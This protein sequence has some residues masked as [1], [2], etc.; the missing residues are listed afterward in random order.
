M[1]LSFWVILSYAGAQT[2]ESWFSG[3]FIFSFVH[4]SS[5]FV[6]VCAC[7]GKRKTKRC[8]FFLLKNCKSAQTYGLLLCN[9]RKT[10]QGQQFEPLWNPKI[11]SWCIHFPNRICAIPI[12]ADSF[13]L[14]S[15]LC[16]TFLFDTRDGISVDWR[17]HLCSGR[18]L[19]I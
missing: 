13:G 10:S 11:E 15:R 17:E 16:C 9:P 7:R 18:S 14:I 6:S 5:V 8:V 3:L 2:K 12:G 19:G 1:Q 4:C